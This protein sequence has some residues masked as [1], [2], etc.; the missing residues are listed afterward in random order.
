MTEPSGKTNFTLNGMTF[1]PN[2]IDVTMKL[3]SIEQWTLVN[4]NSEWH[5][6]HIHTNDFQVVSVAGKPMPYVDYQDNVALPP[7]SHTVILIQPLDFTG[8]F[9]LH[10]HITLHEDRG[11]MATVQVVRE[12]TAAQARRAV[13]Q[14]GGLAIA[15]AAYGSRI[16]PPAVK[17]LLFFCR[18]LGIASAHWRT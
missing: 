8:K 12:P 16:S 14:D 6:F 17:S 1:D 15:S 9:V 5:T 3:G 2:R 11:M 7:H 18:A 13:V 10:C 4:E